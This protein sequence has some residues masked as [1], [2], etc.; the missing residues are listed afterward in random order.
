[1][2]E[3]LLRFLPPCGNRQ[4][5]QRYIVRMSLRERV[6]KF[7][8]WVIKGLDIQ[9][10]ICYDVLMPTGVFIR[11]EAHREKMRQISLRNGNK[12]PSPKGKKMSQETKDKIRVKKIGI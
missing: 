8:P 3:R 12:P 7:P 1:M 5:Q 4:R 10:Y 2:V 9:Q 11:S 6:R